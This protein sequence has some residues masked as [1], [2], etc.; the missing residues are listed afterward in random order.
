MDQVEAMASR[1]FHGQ[2]RGGG[3]AHQGAD[4]GTYGLVQQF[5]AAAAGHQGEAAAGVDTFA[6][7]CA[8]QFVES[9]V[10]ADVLA[11]QADLARRVDEQGG[12]QGAAVACQL[13][14]FAKRRNVR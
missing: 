14:L 4:A 8:N 13:L 3:Q 5:Q 1:P 11:A 6:G 12:M 2:C 10:A 9:V 7:Q